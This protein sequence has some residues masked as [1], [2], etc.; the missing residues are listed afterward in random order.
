[1]D[2]NKDAGRRDRLTSFLRASR[3]RAK[4]RSQ[5]LPGIAAYD[6]SYIRG[7]ETLSALVA[8]L[9]P[10]AYIFIDLLL[11]RAPSYLH[12]MPAF[13]AMLALSLLSF[14][15]GP[16]PLVTSLL[17]AAVYVG[18]ALTLHLPN[19]RAVYIPIFCFAIPF[20]YFIAGGRA[21]RM[22][23]FGFVALVAILVAVGAIA[24]IKDL[25]ALIRPHYYIMLLAALALQLAIAEANEHRHVNGLDVIFDE[26]FYDS[27]TRLP[28]G[29]SLSSEPM[30]EGETLS[31][32]RLR[33][34]RDLR[35]F[36]DD[37]EGREIARRASGILLDFARAREARGPFRVSE[38]EFALIYPRGVEPRAAANALLVEFSRECV[39]KDSPLRFEIQI[40]SYRTGRE[41]E[42]ARMVIEEAE[43]AL[44]N[45]VAI[46]AS[47]VYREGG[48]S[49]DPEDD[50]KAL[51]PILVKNIS[52]RSLFAVFQPVYDVRRGGIGF[53]EALT[54]L[55]LD[56]NLVSPEAYL[57]ASN[58]LGLDKY[59]G[60]FIVESALDMA[61]RSGHSVSFNVTYRD[62]E[63][64]KFLEALFKAYATLSGMSNT[65][66]VELTEHAAFSDYDRIASFAAAVHEAGGLVILDD[67]GT[68]YSNYASLLKARFDV[69]K[70]AGEIVR[71]IVARREAAELYF[72]L[73]AFCRAAGLDV[74]AEH[75]SDESIMARALEG[76]AALLQGY[77]FSRPVEADRIL[78]GAL[79]FP[80]GRSTAPEPLGRPIAPGA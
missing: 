16:S 42:D 7:V 61:L 22:A 47:S 12:Y 10:L 76:G 29:N 40:G 33:N 63:R 1:M 46:D 20:F 27:A 23:S 54:R 26:H 3:T 35:S 57:S 75:I 71:E 19:A 53:L 37:A 67:F 72:G 70:V 59:F 18:F 4:G 17:V 36:Y 69:V 34:F 74:V 51:A 6:S 21:G 68:G 60:D 55:R 8:A 56:G 43:S 50:F 31:L 30:A 38:S 41:G 78:S 39:T 13:L 44:A 48:S 11:G 58:R 64:P 52:E 65:L 66:I 14:R 5:S 73:C 77:H 2:P 15:F 9:F 79:V 80:D 32:I 24:G 62:L 45:C 25:Q 28:N 49:G